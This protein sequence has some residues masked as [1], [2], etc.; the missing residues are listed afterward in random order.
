MGSAP[1][2]VTHHQF[3]GWRMSLSAHD[4]YI[5]CHSKWTRT[6]TRFAAATLSDEEGRAVV[7]VVFAP[8]LLPNLSRSRISRRWVRGWVRAV[9]AT[10]IGSL[11]LWGLTINVVDPLTQRSLRWAMATAGV[12][13][14]R[15]GD[16]PEGAQR[17]WELLDVCH[18]I[19]WH[20]LVMGAAASSGPPC[21]GSP[22]GLGTGPAWWPS[23]E[24][25]SWV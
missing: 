20:V 17:H 12:V 6:E 9:D 4:W 13:P 22:S 23:W 5:T 21:S 18:Y 11:V 8:M 2:P 15:L 24:Q 25:A 14:A 7:V 19:L 3:W 10:V 16:L 1:V